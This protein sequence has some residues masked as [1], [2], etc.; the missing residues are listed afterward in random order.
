MQVI[1]INSTYY[2]SSCAFCHCRGHSITRCNSPRIDEYYYR[3][4]EDLTIYLMSY[5]YANE[6]A[7]RLHLERHALSFYSSATFRAILLHRLFINVGNLK[8][9]VL[10]RMLLDYMYFNHVS[11]ERPNIVPATI[12]LQLAKPKKQPVKKIMVVMEEDADT[13]TDFECSICLEVRGQDKYVSFGC[14]HQ[15]CDDCA[16]KLLMMNHKPCCALCRKDINMLAV[17]S[18]VVY[19]RFV[20]L[21]N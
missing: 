13:N 10:I 20:K 7:R 5:D 11:V 17:K 16:K 15:F 8:R 14:N 12:S 2:R 9:D 19:D 4:Y 6:T 3:I 1:Y 21:C 18:D